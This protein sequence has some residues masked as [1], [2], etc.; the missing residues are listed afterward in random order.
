PGANAETPAMPDTNQDEQLLRGAGVTPDGPGLLAFFRKRV[1][2]EE[3]RQR[4]EELVSKL[5]SRTFRDRE[6]ASTELVKLG[7][8]ARPALARARSEEHTSELQSLT[9]L[10]CRL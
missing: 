10:V 5:G 9:N 2:T 3:D 7:L 8:A 4:A 1:P 6:K